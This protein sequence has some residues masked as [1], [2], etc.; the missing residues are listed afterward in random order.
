[1]TDQ[2]ADAAF[3]QMSFWDKHRFLLLI[4]ITIGISLLLVGISMALYT[5]SGT[6]QLDLSRPGYRGVSSQAAVPDKDFD[7]YATFGPIDKTSISEFNTL[8]NK[9]ATKAKAVDAFSGDPLDPDAL[10]ISP[11]IATP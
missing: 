8:Y 6:A 1:M 3:E 10:E 5:S 2:E 7:T 4:A 9:Q 11:P